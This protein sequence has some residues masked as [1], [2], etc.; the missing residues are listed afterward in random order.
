MAT[1]MRLAGRTTGGMV[2]SI[3]MEYVTG[4]LSTSSLK[5]SSYLVRIV[6]KFILTGCVQL[7]DFL[8]KCKKSHA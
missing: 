5:R 3:L 8:V 2:G 6:C 1:G 4:S 7:V